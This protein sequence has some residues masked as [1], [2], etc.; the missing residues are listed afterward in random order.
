MLASS[1]FIFTENENLKI[2]NQGLR[3]LVEKER[4]VKKL[5]EEENL[6]ALLEITR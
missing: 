6:A 3:S 4:E 1:E 5:Y 2:E